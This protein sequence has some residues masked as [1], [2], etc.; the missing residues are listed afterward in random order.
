MPYI[1]IMKTTADKGSRRVELH[2]VQYRKTERGWEFWGLSQETADWQWMPV[3]G[4]G[5]A[6]LISALEAL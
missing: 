1:E 6:S 5:A 3:R 2:G 4:R